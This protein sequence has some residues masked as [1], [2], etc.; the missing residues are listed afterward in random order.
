[1][2]SRKDLEREGYKCQWGFFNAQLLERFKIDNPLYGFEEN[3]YEMELGTNDEHLIAK[4][5]K[6]LLKYE[7]E[8]LKACR[9][10]SKSS[11]LYNK[12]G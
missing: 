9:T 8:Q 2:K 10:K 12:M 11:R 6:L 1:M 5:Y 3:V 4:M 7:R